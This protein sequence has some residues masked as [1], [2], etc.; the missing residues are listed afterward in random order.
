MET[1][2]TA[3]LPQLL[4][5]AWESRAAFH[6][7]QAT[8]CYRIFHGYSE[9][10]PGLSIDRYGSAAVIN[11]KVELFISD[12]DL[13]T[14][15]RSLFPFEKVVQKS[16]Q[17]VSTDRGPRVQY[18]Y[19]ERSAAPHKV[20]EGGDWY[21][22]D[23]D[24]LHSNGL[25]MDTR[26]ARR[27]LKDH[28]QGRRVYNLFAHTGSL[29]VAAR[30]GGAKDV[31]HID[32][33]PEALAKIRITLELNDLR[34]DDR[35]ILR[36]DIYYHLP[37][38]V[39]WGQKFSGIILDPPPFIPPPLRKPD[40]KPEGQDFATLIDWSCKL[41]DQD[42]WLL[43]VYHDFRKSHDE[44]DQ[45]IVRASGGTLMPVWRDR[46][47]ADFIESDD[48]RWTRMSAFERTNNR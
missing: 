25:F 29:G 8:D 38:A 20:K 28:S 5:A 2:I 40:H 31:V 12:A 18:L 10:L 41:L 14:S 34:H 24:D 22:A 26:P 1:E 21:F 23:L 37:R 19:G 15:L 32:K 42:G 9:G 7:H 27:W 4:T 48:N 35:S 44:H 46:A 17:R 6:A 43:C 3:N 47:D 45:D 11:K 30:L 33:S 13:V 16:H 36:G 39:K